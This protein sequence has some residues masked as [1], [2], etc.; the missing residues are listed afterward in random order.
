MKKTGLLLLFILAIS[1]VK[2]QDSYQNDEVRTVFSK[3]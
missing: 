2:A 3:K 1:I